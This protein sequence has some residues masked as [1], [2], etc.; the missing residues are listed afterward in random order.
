MKIPSSPPRLHLSQAVLPLLH[1]RRDGEA[2]HSLADIDEHV[3]NSISSSHLSESYTAEL[4]AG[5]TDRQ[6]EAAG[7]EGRAEVMIR[8]GEGQGWRVGGREGATVES[9]TEVDAAGVGGNV[10]GDKRERAS[11]AE[12]MDNKWVEKPKKETKEARKP[13]EEAIEVAEMEDEKKI[14]D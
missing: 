12:E 1:A 2:N 13:E 6:G 5:W 3:R 9:G 7:T 14:L 10:R 8:G 11:H 4:L